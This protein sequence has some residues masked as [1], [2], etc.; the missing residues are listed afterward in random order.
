METVVVP[1]VNGVK[2]SRRLAEKILFWARKPAGC[3]FVRCG[4]EDGG[5]AGVDRLVLEAYQCL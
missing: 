2:H 3:R 1:Y 5:A 4:G